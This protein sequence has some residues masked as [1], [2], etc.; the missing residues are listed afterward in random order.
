MNTQIKLK[1]PVQH[2]KNFLSL[3]WKAFIVISIVIIIVNGS[4][5][6]FHYLNL[7]KEYRKQRLEVQEQNI[8]MLNSVFEKSDKQLQN[9]ANLIPELNG[10][11]DIIDNIGELAKDRNSF[12]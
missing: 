7:S 8:V 4:Y 5:Y 1:D 2:I 3:K 12:Q 11:K 9:M 10:V 6:I